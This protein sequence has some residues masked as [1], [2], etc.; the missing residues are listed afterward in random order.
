MPT[1]MPTPADLGQHLVRHWRTILITTVAMVAL[2]VTFALLR[3]PTWRATQA[4]IVRAEAST[5]AER[6]GKFRDADDMKTV[7]ETILQLATSRAVLDR[8]LRE[9][10]PAPGKTRAA[11]FP[12][13]QDIDDLRGAV[14]VKPPK[15][16]EFGK[17]ELF[18]VSVGDRSRE[19]AIQLAAAVSRALQHRYA[20]LL[21][22][23]AQGMIQELERAV[24]VAE[25]DLAKAAG[26]LGALEASVGP[27]LAELR[28]LND[29]PAGSSDL[30]Q[31]LI[32][33]EN[34]QRQ[35]KNEM[36]Q[37]E[38][39]YALLQSAQADPEMLLAT[40]SR[41]IESQPG[42]KRLKEG[43]IDA[44]L[45]SAALLGSVSKEH[46]RAQAAVR[47][48]AEVRGNL[49]SELG[50]ALRGAQAE[51]RLAQARIAAL[52]DQLG[53]T[54]Q[55]LEKLAGLRANYASLA[56]ANTNA[57]QLVEKARRDLTEA[58]SSQIAAH[59]AG[60]LSPVDQPETGPRPIGPG[61]TM[62]A[63]AGLVGGLAS[64][65]GLV[66]LLTPLPKPNQPDSAA[67]APRA[68]GHSIPKASVSADTAGLSLKEAL[69]KVAPGRWN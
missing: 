33:I 62:I 20:E 41:L 59:T 9:V 45:R 15:G 3:Q 32:A 6:A 12:N 57:L 66:L 1:A 48:E 18:Y 67:P 34:E 10:G 50:T 27:D 46:P 28:I 49:H 68:N 25:G 21:E 30:R 4:L 55:R 44:Q 13:E 58:R 29:S 54:K 47:A 36:R 14:A 26:Q 39:L 16:A 5:S 8:A 19:R 69:R 60:M 43:L 52:E 11:N 35:A 53:D 38:E 7:Q 22:T 51:I 61:K 31:R 24:A 64:G 2:A 23:K 37:A 65:I 17:T 56:A 42:L 63:L 40:P